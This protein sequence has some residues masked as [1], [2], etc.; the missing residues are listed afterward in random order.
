MDNFLRLAQWNA[1][2]LS[3]H[4]GEV[5]LFLKQNYY[6]LFLNSE[7]RFSNKSYLNILNYKLYCIILIIQAVQLTMVQQ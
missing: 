4:K 2:G 6:D 5:K 7:T 1:N 3:N